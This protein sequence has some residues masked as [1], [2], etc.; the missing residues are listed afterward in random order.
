[1]SVVLQT[2]PIPFKFNSEE[3]WA[4]CRKIL[5]SKL[6]FSPHDYQL[7]GVTRILDGEDVLAIMATGSGKSA[8]IYMPILVIQ[9]IKEDLALCRHTN[10]PSNPVVIVV[11]PTTALEE[12]QEAK[13]NKMGVAALTINSITVKEPTESEPSIWTAAKTDPAVILV[14]PEM[15][16]TDPFR[17]LLAKTEFRSRLFAIVI[18]EI[19]LLTTWG[20]TFRPTY[21]Q[22]AYV[23]ERIPSSVNFIGLTAT[24]RPGEHMDGICKHAR[25]KSGYHLIRRS[26]ARPEIQFII[27]PFHAN[28]ASHSFPQL[29]WVFQVDGLV[30]IC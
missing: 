6:P 19:H 30:V 20:E 15:L 13:L 29:D 28:Y 17:T 22:I 5:G 18:D 23:R 4:L 25:F 12:D 3:G 10:L 21:E 8:Y 27:R 2:T 7:E 26:N 9:A 24:L 11:V 16:S 1:M 14:S